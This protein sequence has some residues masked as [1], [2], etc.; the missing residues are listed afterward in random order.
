VVKKPVNDD[1]RLA[2]Q[3]DKLIQELVKRG[4]RGIFFLYKGFVN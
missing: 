4:L 2:T 1:A 3:N